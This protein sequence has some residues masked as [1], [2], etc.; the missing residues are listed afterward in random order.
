MIRFTPIQDNPEFPND[1]ETCW[2]WDTARPAKEGDELP[3]TAV[4]VYCDNDPN[5][6]VKIEG[7]MRLLFTDQAE[8]YAVCP[9]CHFIYRHMQ[10]SGS[11][12]NRN[13]RQ[14]SQAYLEQHQN[15]KGWCE[16]CD[17]IFGSGGWRE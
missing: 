17:P 8:Y 11:T 14:D 10:W 1:G 4:Q 6:F 15:Q 7:D 9:D 12:R 13:W 2:Y 3:F 16:F 5:K